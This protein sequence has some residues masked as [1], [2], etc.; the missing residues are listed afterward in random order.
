[1]LDT[2]GTPTGD[3][4]S[5]STNG[6]HAPQGTS[7]TISVAMNATYT[8]V[9]GDF[10]FSD[11]GDYPPDNFVGVKITTTPAHG[12]LYTVGG[13]WTG[14]PTAIVA[15]DFIDVAIIAAGGL[16][17]VPGTGKHGSPYASF[18]FQVQDD[19]GLCNGGA[20]LDPNPKTITIN[21]T[22]INHAPVGAN[23]NPSVSFAVPTTTMYELSA[24]QFGFTDPN[25]S[26]PDNFL[27]VKITTLPASGTLY[28]GIDNQAVIAGQYVPV[29]GINRGW[30]YYAPPSPFNPFS[31]SF[32]FQVQDDGGTDGGGVDTDVSPRYFYLHRP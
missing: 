4:V 20:N 24:S 13:G 2:S 28:Y 1:M 7:E 5:I 32:E 14:T 26:P 22:R 25:D 6:G 12:T 15:G 16:T 29:S 18:T 9:L 11:P 17:Y 10:R 31:T 3:T 8:F 30:F 21:V 27:A 23:G 19:G